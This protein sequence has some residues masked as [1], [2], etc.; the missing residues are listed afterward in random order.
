MPHGLAARP[1]PYAMRWPIGR[2]R[3]VVTLSGAGMT[4]AAAGLR[5]DF[6][7]R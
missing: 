6:R 1:A 4:I 3:S 5:S 7:G 2:D